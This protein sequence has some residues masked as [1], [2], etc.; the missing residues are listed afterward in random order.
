VRQ[1]KR[2]VNSGN[3]RVLALD[4]KGRVLNETGPINAVDPGGGVFG[5]DGR[6]YVGSRGL[7][8]ILVIPRRLEGPAIPYLPPEVVP[9]P[10][11]F[12]FASDGRAFSASGIGPS[13]NGENAIKVFDADGQLQVSRLV[14]DP[15]LSPLDLSIAPNGNIVV[16]SEWPF[17][18]NDA[19]SS[20]REYDST[21]GRLG[22]G[23]LSNPSET[24]TITAV[25]QPVTSTN[26]VP[27]NPYSSN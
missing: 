15:Q 25:Y 12:A 17:G 22:G 3:D 11:G 10:R 23:P 26:A 4:Q 19:I 5:S 18:E 14:E 21:S 7:R 6:Y 20:L 27:P 13:G 16:S 24:E 1:S 9:F 8:T 2:R